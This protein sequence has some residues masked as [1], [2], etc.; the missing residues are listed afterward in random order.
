MKLISDTDSLM[1][2]YAG[3]NLEDIVRPEKVD[4]WKEVVRAW[5]SVPGDNRSCKTPG[6]LKTEKKINSG[7]FIALTPKVCRLYS[8]LLLHNINSF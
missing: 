2:G 5:F 1:L 6:L 8:Y 3:E 4:S 7:H